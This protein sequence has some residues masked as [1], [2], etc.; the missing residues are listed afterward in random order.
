VTETTRT[1]V[2]EP[3]VVAAAQRGDREAQRALYER[4]R[5]RVFSLVVHMVADEDA[6]EDVLQAVFLRVFR[7]LGGFRGDASLA[8]WIYRIAL[9]ESRRHRSR[10]RSASVPIEELFGSGEELDAGPRPDAAYS[11]D[12]RREI[13]SRAVQELSPRLREVVV[14]RYVEELSYEQIASVL[15]CAEGTVASRLHRALAELESRLRVVRRFL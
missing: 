1:N 10:S 3:V 2:D 15:G 4:Y 11:S 8:T 14:L 13:V 9:N 6:A 12:Q 5:D 7:S